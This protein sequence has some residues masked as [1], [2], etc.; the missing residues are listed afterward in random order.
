MRGQLPRPASGCSFHRRSSTDTSH[1]CHHISVALTRGTSFQRRQVN[2]P[3][4]E[5]LR[6][7]QACPAFFSVTTRLVSPDLTESSSM[8]IHKRITSSFVINLSLTRRSSCSKSG[9]SGYAS[10]MCAIHFPNT[11]L[12]DRAERR[13]EARQASRNKL[14][15]ALRGSGATTRR[16]NCSLVS[17]TLAPILPALDHRWIRHSASVPSNAKFN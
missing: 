9:P 11:V 10:I 13:R 2:F 7:K 4:P 8:Q 6:M 3:V 12:L 15:R 14:H 5:H 1:W 16:T 17:L